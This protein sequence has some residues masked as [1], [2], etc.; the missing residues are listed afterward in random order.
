MDAAAE[1]EYASE[2]T[3]RMANPRPKPKP[4]PK[5]NPNPNPNPNPY[6]NPNPNQVMPLSRIAE[7]KWR[8]PCLM[9]ASDGVWDLWNYN[10]VVDELVSPE[11]ADPA[12]MARRAADFCEDTRSK[13]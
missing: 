5:P 7:R 2:V 6:P 9:L 13:G 3:L 1:V 12:R 8:Q 11:N 10:E 4:N